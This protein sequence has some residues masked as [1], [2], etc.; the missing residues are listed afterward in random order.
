MNKDGKAMQAGYDPNRLLD[1]VMLRMG[2]TNDGAL[3]RFLKVA[4]PVIRG[5]RHGRLPVA[6]SLLMWMHE[7]TGMSIAELRLLLGDRR[8]RYRLAYA[9]AKLRPASV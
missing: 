6:A 5:I 9:T 8:A 7:A 3:A 2:L 4:Q 1:A